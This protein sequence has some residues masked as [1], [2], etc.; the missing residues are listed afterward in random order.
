M[1][2]LTIRVASWSNLPSGRA[3]SDGPHSGEAF[4]EDVLVPALRANDNVTLDTSGVYGLAN[5]WLEE[6]FGGLVRSNHMT[7]E[8]LKKRLDLSLLPP[9]TAANIQSFIAEAQH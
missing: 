8:N 1:A 6:V 4:R 5:S 3:R 2:H 9:L 7:P